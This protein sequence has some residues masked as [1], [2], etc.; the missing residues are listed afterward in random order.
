MVLKILPKVLEGVQL[1]HVC[2]TKNYLELKNKVEKLD[3]KSKHRY[4]IYPFLTDELKDAYALCDAVI[5]RA[6]A[7]TLSEI[8][9]LEK[10]SIIIPLP[11]SANNHQLQNAEFFAEKGMVSSIKEENLTVDILRTELFKILQKN[12]FRD[13]MTKKIE[14]YNY[15]KKN[16]AKIIAEEI[17]SFN[18]K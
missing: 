17:I 8:I 10:P 3:I 12:D 15:D 18:N 1:I 5:S 9:A 13:S 7:N 6:G 16:A 4:K 14:N 11:T 2:G